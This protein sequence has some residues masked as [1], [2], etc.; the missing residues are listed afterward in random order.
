MENPFGARRP[1]WA[2][3]VG[4]G[5]LPRR[6]SRRPE[7]W[8][9][10][11]EP[12]EGASVLGDLSLAAGD[13]RE[14]AGV[15]ARYA[16]L[17][18]VLRAARG[19]T[20]GRDLVEERAAA[21]EYV[22]A[23]ENVDGAERRALR[24]AVRLAGRSPGRVLAMALIGAGVAAARRGHP[25][26][27]LALYRAGYHLGVERGW[28]AEAALA[29]AAIARLAERGGGYWAP[30]RW[31]RRAAVLARRAASERAE[32]DRRSGGARHSRLR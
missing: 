25:A 4:A 19:A 5:E 15:L 11:D 12:F 13:P 14:A 2:R 18:L 10:E 17:R 27:A 8:E 28:T 31:R 23:Q 32:A 22:D 7:P 29:A 3:V 26:G 16:V 21:L 1:V 6:W 20:E 30:R 9:I 24:A